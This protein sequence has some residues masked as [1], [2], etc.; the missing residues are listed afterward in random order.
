MR[1]FLLMTLIL[2][3]G[4]SVAAGGRIAYGWWWDSAHTV[5]L[6]YHHS[7][8]E[9]NTPFDV[10][11]DAYW[12][13]ENDPITSVHIQIK[14]P[15]TARLIDDVNIPIN[16]N[17]MLKWDTWSDDL[18]PGEPVDPE[19]EAPNGLCV[20]ATGSPGGSDCYSTTL[21]PMQGMCPPCP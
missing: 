6:G 18:D 9:Y 14:C 7:Q 17:P 20:I 5:M 10:S 16:N 2:G 21:V 1:R 3:L 12:T 19:D 13:D 15:Q 8:V 11:G 4:V